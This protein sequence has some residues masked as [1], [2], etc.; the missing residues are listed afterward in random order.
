MMRLWHNP[1][2]SKS[3]TAIKLLEDAKADF[4]VYLYLA[5]AP[6]IEEIDAL[7]DK[8]GT[9]A[10]Q[11]LRTGEPEWR[12]T[13]LSLESAETAIRRAMA[14]FPILIQR[15]ILETGDR[16]VVGRPPERVLDL[17]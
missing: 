10:A 11:L 6:R 14:A 13:G 12:V 4:E 8:L 17:L 7:I 2:C 1:R 15:P 9:T 16:A 5:R 3:R